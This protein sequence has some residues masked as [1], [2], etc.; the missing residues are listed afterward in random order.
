MAETNVE[1]EEL[2]SSVCTGLYSSIMTAYECVHSSII[3][4]HEAGGPSKLI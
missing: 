2:C 1:G 3:T 4:A